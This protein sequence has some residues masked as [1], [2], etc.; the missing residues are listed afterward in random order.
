MLQNLIAVSNAIKIGHNASRCSH[1]M[2][3]RAWLMERYIIFSMICWWTLLCSGDLTAYNTHD[4]AGNPSKANCGT[5]LNK[6]AGSCPKASL[7]HFQTGFIDWPYIIIGWRS[8]IHRERSIH[9]HHWPRREK[10]VLYI[11]HHLYQ[12]KM[13]RALSLYLHNVKWLYMSERPIRAWPF[14]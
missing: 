8:E 13:T 5:V 3:D 2:C 1:D 7:F 12:D 10:D 9:F 11:I 6:V 4:V 14:E